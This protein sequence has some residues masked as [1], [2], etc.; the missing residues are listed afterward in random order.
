MVQS[1]AGDD[2]PGADL[3]A[4]RC[5]AASCIYTCTK[6]VEERSHRLLWMSHVC[7]VRYGLPGSNQIYVFIV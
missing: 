2:E 5:S 6:A 3:Y 1:F 7:A 4:G